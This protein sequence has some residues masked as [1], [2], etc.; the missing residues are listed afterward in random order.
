MAIKP[1]G[2]PSVPGRPAELQDCLWSR[3]RER[4]PDTC[5]VH[6]LDMPTSGL[7]VFARGVD[8]QRILSAAFSARRVDKR[9]A[10]VV[11]GP[12]PHGEEGQIDLPIAADWP[13]RPR[14][15]ICALTGKAST[16]RWQRR[17]R[18]EGRKVALLLQPVTGRTHQ[19]RLHLAAIGHPIVGDAL[20]GEGPLQG[21]DRLMLHAC[22][23]GFEHPRTG[24][25]MRFQCA[26]PFSLDS[27]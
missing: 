12:W 10:A 17:S 8:A 22:E 20:Y 27:P 24:K 7:M 5:I 25:A 2:L 19:L 13:R 21:G 3:L 6:R 1:P 11:Q 9:Y 15:R 14:Q 16:T 23:L 4:H 26:A 18:A